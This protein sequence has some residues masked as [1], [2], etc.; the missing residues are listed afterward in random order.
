MPTARV[1]GCRDR[2]ALVAVE[3]VV[4][5]RAREPVALEGWVGM[6]H[7][8]VAAVWR[9]PARGRG[10]RVERALVLARADW[11]DWVPEAVRDWVQEPGRKCPDCPVVARAGRIRMDRSPA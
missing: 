10:W 7:A 3:M 6:A 9:H 5:G 1:G 11:L 8:W 4:Q 2:V